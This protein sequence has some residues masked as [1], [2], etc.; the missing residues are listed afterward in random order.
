MKRF[1]NL[2]WFVIG[3]KVKQ[4]FENMFFTRF[5]SKIIRKF[6]EKDVFQS[7]VKIYQFPEFLIN[8]RGPILNF[9]TLSRAQI[10]S[11]T[12]CFV[13]NGL[14]PKYIL[15]I[16]N[17]LIPGIESICMPTRGTVKGTHVSQYIIT[18]WGLTEKNSRS[19]ILLQAL[20]P[21]V[22]SN[23]CRRT[24]NVKISYSQICAGGRTQ[25][26]CAGDSGGPLQNYGKNSQ[27]IQFGLISYG[28]RNC[29][30]YNVPTVYTNIA[31][32]MDW[33]RDTIK[34]N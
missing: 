21:F 18:G 23:T 26:A 12:D 3:R 8:L 7:L 30:K 28:Q 4:Y 17:H 27:M 14:K 19:D 5:V 9:Q 29:A 1:L 13:L 2:A 33:I 34:N 25:D 32:F 22:D 16:P 6:N 11:Q 10:Q 24:L 15:Y 31:T 20:V